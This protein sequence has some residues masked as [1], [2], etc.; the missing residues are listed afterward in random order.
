MNNY[1]VYKKYKKYKK[2]Y[3]QL[4]F[5]Q[6]SGNSIDDLD[7]LADSF[8]QMNLSP[9]IDEPQSNFIQVYLPE[10]SFQQ[11]IGESVEKADCCPCVFLALGLI[12]SK[13]F[14]ILSQTYG[15][16][17]GYSKEQMEKTWREV[18]GNHN[19]LFSL[20]N[21]RDGTEKTVV[22]ITDQHLETVY[23]N[24]SPSHA[25]IAGIERS[26]KTKHCVILCKTSNGILILIDA[27]L[28][29]NIA[30]QPSDKQNVSCW[31]VGAS[32]IGLYLR[33]N[34][35]TKLFILEGTHKKNNKP[36]ILNQSVL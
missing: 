3:N 29:R 9:G 11:K 7:D 17:G 4:R 14:N 26:N 20:I 12:T 24:I 2:K 5:Y 8:S 33:N 6:I 30:L 22:D 23:K 10:D 1:K 21:S 16:A 32:D 28:C 34:N 13:M 18:Y 15:A 31:G 36:L 35:V 27:Q 19:I 25:V